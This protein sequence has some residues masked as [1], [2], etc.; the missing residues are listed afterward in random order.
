ML[1]SKA[2][3]KLAPNFIVFSNVAATDGGKAIAHGNARVLAARLNDARYFW[4][5]DRKT[6]LASRVEK[7]DKIVF[8]QKIGSIGD[9][10]KRIEELAGQLALIAVSYTHLDVYKRQ[11]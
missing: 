9:K 5:L 8:H 7:L 4:D 3:D 2:T 1:N 10:V 11:T 6:T